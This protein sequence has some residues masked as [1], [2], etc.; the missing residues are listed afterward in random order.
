[1]IYLAAIWL[2][3]LLFKLIFTLR[4]MKRG[5]QAGCGVPQATATILQPV[6]SGDPQ[7][8][9]VLEANVV[10]LK[11]A[12]FFWLI[13][14]DD[15]V[16]REIAISIQSRYPDRE[17]KAS[18]FPPAPEGVNP[19]VFKLEQAWREVESDILLVLDDDAFLSAESFGT[20]L[21]QIEEGALVTALP[22]Y[23]ADSNGY[24]RLL[25]QFVNDNSGFTYLPLLPFSPPLTING[26]CYAI[27]V[28]TL[29]QVGGFAAILHD[30]ADDLALATLLRQHHIRLIQSTAP[31]RVQTSLSSGK[32]YIQQMHRWFLF[33]TLLLREKTVLI[34]LIIF[35]L[36]GLHPLL[37]WAMLLTVGWEWVTAAH[38][39]TG[40]NL[41][42]IA[43]CLL[44]RHA[45]LRHVQQAIA[46]DIR[47]NPIFSLL[48]ELM[49]PLHLLHALCNRTI[50][51]RTRRYRVLSNKKFNSL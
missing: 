38:G 29:A 8:A 36:Q 1:M 28:N 44:I 2:G 31:V 9:T 49:Q 14:D 27:S 10:A 7:L 46:P 20:L 19:K 47:S 40:I 15:T 26:M 13:D 51:W 21:N 33:A 24:S 16:A 42:I 30:L 4:M 11:Q 37:M 41:G 17:I 50:Y 23:C 6:L 32:K 39:I 35:L 45:A 25:A 34:K 48:S 18:Y 3:I 5:K 12:R 43:A 22:Y